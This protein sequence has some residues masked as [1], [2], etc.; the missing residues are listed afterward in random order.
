MP[1]IEWTQS[2]PSELAML[3][4]RIIEQIPDATYDLAVDEASRGETEMKERA[5]W[6]DRSTNARNGLFGKA[7][8]TDT[9]AVIYL[10]GTMDY[11]P[12]LELGTRY[13]RPYPIIMP[14]TKEVRV[15]AIEG[16]GEVI[17][18][19]LGGMPG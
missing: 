4:A 17:S 6:A 14:V 18:K 8:R 11:Q 13:M 15:T 7:E 10:G 5:P 3:L 1:G 12:Y 9:G 16:M 19:L 2:S